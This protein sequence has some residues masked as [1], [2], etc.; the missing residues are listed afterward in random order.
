MSIYEVKLELERPK[1]FLDGSS[2]ALQ[3]QNVLPDATAE[4]LERN[5]QQAPRKNPW[6][7]SLSVENTTAE[8]SKELQAAITAYYTEQV[9]SS[10]ADLRQHWHTT[11]QIFVY[12]GIFLGLCLGL[13]QLLEQVLAERFPDFISEGLIIIGWVALWRPAEMLTY[14]WLPL[15]RRLNLQRKLSQLSVQVSRD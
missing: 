11:R 14:D 8:E 10:R 3:S 4:F 6:V 5:F 1:A 12:G 13:Q 15:V 7:L 9:Q 2:P